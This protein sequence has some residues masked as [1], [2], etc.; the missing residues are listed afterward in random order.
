MKNGEAKGILY[1]LNSIK[2]VRKIQLGFFLIGLMSTIIAVSNYLQVD[3]FQNIKNSIFDEYIHPKDKIAT[4]YNDFQNIQSYMLKFSLG[5]YFDDFDGDIASVNEKKAKIDNLF[6]E[7]K[8]SS[9][10]DEIKNDLTQAQDVWSQYKNVVTDAVISA[11]VT[12]NFEMAA[13]ISATSGQEVGNQLNANFENIVVKLAAHATRLDTQM[14]EDVGASK[15]FIIWGMIFGGIVFVF[16]AFY[17]APNISKPLR[18][19]HDAMAKFALGDYDVTVEINSKDEFG[20]LAVM[21][22]K[23]KQA[24]RE[25]VAAAEKIAA[26]IFEKVPLASENDALAIA[27]NHEIEILNSLISEGNKLIEANQAGKLDI[28]GN[29]KAFKGDW[30][31]FIGGMN[32]IL[33]SIITPINEASEVLETMASGD[34]TNKM[35]GEYRGDYEKI[36]INVNKVIAS[37]SALIGQVTESAYELAGSVSEIS[38]STEQMAAGAGEQSSQANEISISV[39]EMTRTIIDNTQNATEA[40]H[41]AKEAGDRA[42]EGGSV[43][44]KTIEGINRVAEIVVQSAETIKQL[45]AS[46]DK[47]GE[48]IQVIDEIADQT[49]LLAL[50][51]AIEAAR[52]G[53]HGRGFAVVADE[54]RKLAERT[55]KATKEI[56]LMIKHIQN[57]TQGAV[58]AIES[59]STEA[60]KGKQL[61]NEAGN[62]LEEIIKNSQR[63]SDIVNQLATASEE[64]SSAGEQISS[65]IVAITNV[66]QQSAQGIQQISQSTDNLYRR[67]ELLRELV[68]KFKLDNVKQEIDR[69]KTIGNNGNGHSFSHNRYLN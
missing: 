48:I 22:E 47:I 10:N 55:T 57:D 40:S 44:L 36:K 56:A 50:N 60:E 5:D 24:Q 37:L 11:A 69:S 64:Q 19:I 33:D 20:Q 13:I 1:Y 16:S 58:K 38:T 65:S 8:S 62:S 14:T 68:S 9:L 6:E 31:N 30:Q 34:F 3:S 25:K 7:L 12:Q 41:M 29:E 15:S 54:V 43:V 53:E 45:G 51:A 4:L 17:L 32:S 2:F 21:T 18:K 42:R 67:T 46:S 63:V 66:T 49:N 27:F 35:K 26:G 23:L 39:E 59:G 52:A 61:A 28:R